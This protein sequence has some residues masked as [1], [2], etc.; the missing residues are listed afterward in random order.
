MTLD[1][2][3]PFI[4]WMQA[5]PQWAGFATFV[6]SIAE[7][8]A[9]VG[10]LIPGTIVMGA[11][12]SLVGTGILPGL[13]IILWASAGAIVG[14][15][16]SY[17]LGYHYHG[18]IR[19]MW[20]FRSLPKLMQKGEAFFLRHGG[21]SVFIGRFLGPIRPIIPVIAGMMNM[22]PWRFTIANVAS[23]IT[24]APAY[25]LPGY[26]LG[27]LSLQLAPHTATRFLVIAVLAL[28]ALWLAYWIVKEIIWLIHYALEILLKK[29]WATLQH[30]P[31]G[32]VITDPGQPDAHSQL[33][34]L[35]S[36]ALALLLFF[37][38]AIS[39]HPGAGIDN[40]LWS[41]ALNIRTH[42]LEQFMLACTLLGELP[43]IYTLCCSVAFWLVYKRQWRAAAYW[44]GLS[45]AVTLSAA[46]LQITL[47][48]PRPGGLQLSLPGW[49]FPS[50]HI[51]LSC[52][53]YGFLA[54]LLA[55]HTSQHYR[56]YVGIAITF[57]SLISFSRL[58]F[59]AA[60]ASGIVGSLLLGSAFAL[61]FALGYRSKLP[62]KLS[63]WRLACV[64]L[65]AIAIPYG[66]LWYYYQ[67]QLLANYTPQT[68]R[69]ILSK[70]SWWDRQQQ[71]PRYRETITGKAAELMNIEWA[72]DLTPIQK[73]LSKQG[74]EVTPK[75]NLAI[76]LNRIA[77]K[78][79]EEQ[80]PLFPYFYQ[81]QRPALI[82]TKKQP[83][84]KKMLVLRLWDSQLRLADQSVP[85]WLGTIGYHNPWQL[86][87]HSSQKP[88]FGAEYQQAQQQLLQDLPGYIV[89]KAPV[90]TSSCEKLKKGCP[91]YRLLIQSPAG[92]SSIFESDQLCLACN[93]ILL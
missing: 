79:R 45:I 55:R 39:S 15:G 42:H 67:P 47:Q 32:S 35:L 6:I 17:W 37:L 80:L 29:L 58:Y 4:D 36:G 18:H 19:E 62:T 91:P 87:L 68:T 12:G 13:D 9:V 70:S 46:L 76:I 52:A 57:I 38:T 48:V 56:W 82:M 14:D 78:N 10:L 92:H 86:H 75:P 43:I 24:W 85:L 81:H 77:A 5:H 73:A 83:G 54:C 71:L 50:L 20:P 61:F 7:S 21:K 25:M 53:I 66:A 33:T 28:L 63:A 8:L 27:A 72:G 69:Q 23:A 41:L 1:D 49:S 22:P 31:I 90:I 89:K 30:H 84:Q 93:S 11:I 40:Q 51:T 26:L 88:A 16:A 74:W 59:S 64:S 3:K 65:L 44:T 60:W 2:L 34:L